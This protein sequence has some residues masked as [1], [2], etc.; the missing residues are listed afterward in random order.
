MSKSINRSVVGG[1]LGFLGGALVEHGIQALTGTD[2]INGV[3]EVAG[4]VMGVAFVNRDLIE[5][6]YTQIQRQ[7]GK[8]PAEISKDEWEAF[9]K[10][11]PSTANYLEK[12]LAI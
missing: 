12:A 11:N 10:D 1:T 4:A 7:F 3:A 2:F 9:K 5:S 8:E 6:A